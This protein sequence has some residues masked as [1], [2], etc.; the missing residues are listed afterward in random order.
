MMWLKAG[1]VAFEKKALE[2]PEETG[3]VHRL[4]SSVS[5]MEGGFDCLA[6]GS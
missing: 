1:E 2:S 5:V 6:G 3:K 4:I